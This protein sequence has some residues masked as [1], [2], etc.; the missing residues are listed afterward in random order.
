MRTKKP[1]F[2]YLSHQPQKLI[3]KIRSLTKVPYGFPRASKIMI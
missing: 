3:Y 2:T 1:R